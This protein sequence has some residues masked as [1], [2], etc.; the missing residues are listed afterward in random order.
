MGKQGSG[1]GGTRSVGR[2]LLLCCDLF[3]NVPQGT[4]GGPRETFFSDEFLKR[5]TF[6]VPMYEKA[7]K[8]VY[9]K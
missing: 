7:W 4:L 8:T 1:H 5:G 6:Q 9:L 2:P 3:P